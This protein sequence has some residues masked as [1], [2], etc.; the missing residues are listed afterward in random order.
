MSFRES[1]QF[2]LHSGQSRQE[3][4]KSIEEIN[5]FENNFE[6][7]L[8]QTVCAEA[9][10]K[11]FANEN[12]K[13]KKA[14]IMGFDGARADS[15]LGIIK[16]GTDDETALYSGISEMRESHHLYLSFTGGIESDSVTKQETSTASGWA[17]VLTGKWA[18]EHGIKVNNSSS[19]NKETPTFL[20]E[21]ARKGRPCSFNAIWSVHFDGTYKDE[22]KAA[23][24][25]NLPLAH[26][27]LS[28]DAELQ[29]AMI[30]AIDRNDDIIFGIYEEPDINGHQYGYSNHEYH[31][32]RS[33]ADTDRRAYQLIK[34]IESR[35]TY[36]DED[37]LIILTADHGGHAKGHGSTLIQ[38]RTVFI[39]IN[40]EII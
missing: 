25:E 34:H 33:V 32:V 30:K 23:E 2:L 28:T 20:L 4:I 31:Y 7:A 16:A 5:L 12:G 17:T 29:N 9:V 40:K 1:M 10:R 37:W 39:G 6:T 19:I 27:R 8:P 22:I 15:L 21:Y 26:T 36:N 3:Y 11:H 18:N 24:E 13:H 14:I 38:D 35:P